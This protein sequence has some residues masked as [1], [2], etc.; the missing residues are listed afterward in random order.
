[1]ASEYRLVQGEEETKRIPKG[2]GDLLRN[3]SRALT[4]SSSTPVS[5]ESTRIHKGLGVACRTFFILSHASPISVGLTLGFPSSLFHPERTNVHSC[6]REQSHSRLP[7][8]HTQ[9]P[10]VDKTSLHEEEC[11]S[12][13]VIIP[14]RSRAHAYL[15]MQDLP[16]PGGPWTSTTGGSSEQC[17]NCPT[18]SLIWYDLPIHLLLS[19]STAP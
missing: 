10:N 2:T 17:P 5:N 14:Q 11:K 8:V 6:A 4:R 19:S 3:S 16:V 13:I 12:H 7:N 1:M 9:Y 18:S 15:V